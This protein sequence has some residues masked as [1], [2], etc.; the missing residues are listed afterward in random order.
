MLVRQL[1]SA[2]RQCGGLSRVLSTPRGSTGGVCRHRKVL[3]CSLSSVAEKALNL[4]SIRPAEWYEEQGR[5]RNYFYVGCRVARNCKLDCPS[6]DSNGVLKRRVPMSVGLS[7]IHLVLCWQFV[8]LKGR[9]YLEEVSPKNIATSFK[10]PKFLDFFF[11]RLQP[12]RTGLHP[13]YLYVSPCGREMNFVNAADR[14]IVFTELQDGN[15]VYAPSLSV[16]FDPAALVFCDSGRLYHPAPGTKCGGLG[17]M[18]TQLAGQI[19]ATMTL[20][21]SGT[22][23]VY[24]WAGCEHTISYAPDPEQFAGSTA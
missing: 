21:D 20:D 6:R 7:L 17:L 5:A 8:D 12:N 16:P 4:P 23:Y 13:D 18:H 24:E 3:A 1:G 11:R 14:V 15:L 19:A 2:P 22:N 9:L 10:A